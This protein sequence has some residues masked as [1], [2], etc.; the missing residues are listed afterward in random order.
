MA[1]NKKIYQTFYPVVIKRSSRVRFVFFMQFQHVVESGF[2]VAGSFILHWISLF[3]VTKQT[4]P[5]EMLTCFIGRGWIRSDKHR[6][7]L[8]SIPLLTFSSDN[9]FPT[10]YASVHL[11]TSFMPDHQPSLKKKKKLTVVKSLMRCG[12][13]CGM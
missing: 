13:K 11:F 3:P 1:W 10:L 6:P 8:F 2:S 9:F 7:D 4:V 5:T 12:K